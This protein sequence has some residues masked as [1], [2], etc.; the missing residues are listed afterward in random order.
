MPKK[1]SKIETPTPV[2]DVINLDDISEEEITTDMGVLADVVHQIENNESS[3]DQTKTIGDIKQKSDQ[4]PK[5]G[6]K[7]ETP[8]PA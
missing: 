5:K 3:E 1:G 4:M 7:T 8:T 6:L 2:S